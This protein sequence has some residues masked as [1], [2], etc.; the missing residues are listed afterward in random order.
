[1]TFEEFVKFIN[2]LSQRS[3]EV[4]PSYDIIK[5]LF[6]FIDLRE[7]GFLDIHEWM[8]SFRQIDV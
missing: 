7:D 1:M 6:V 3:N 4:P 5:D 8:Q 2:I